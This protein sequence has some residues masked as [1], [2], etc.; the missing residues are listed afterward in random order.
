MVEDAAQAHGAYFEN[1]RTGNL[2]DVAGFSLPWENLG[3][4][5]DGGAITTNNLELANTVRAL[6]NY[7]S[8]KSITTLLRENSRLDELQAGFLSVKLKSLDKETL[9]EKRLQNIQRELIT[10]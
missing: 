5:G 10:K 3:A 6:G 7:G 1:K 8:E 9:L 2:G 4:L